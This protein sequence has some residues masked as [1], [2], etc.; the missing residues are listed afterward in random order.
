M[1]D[2]EL[3]T[4][5]L[6]DAYYFVSVDKPAK[7]R[8]YLTHALFYL[9]PIKDDYSDTRDMFCGINLIKYSLEKE[10]HRMNTKS[11]SLS[12]LD[13]MIDLAGAWCDCRRWA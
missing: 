9:R 1:D 8:L 2:L 3:L 12:I 13:N 10:W 7:A 4:D 11:F 6:A 5:A